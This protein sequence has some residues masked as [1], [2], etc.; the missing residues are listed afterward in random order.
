MSKL[1]IDNRT[2]RETEYLLA[3][4]GAVLMLG[5]DGRVDGAK[6]EFDDGVRF[7]VIRN[8]RSMRYLV[9]QG[10]SMEVDGVPG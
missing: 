2:G 6:I 10:N 1:I 9:L 8:E 7:E 4:L 3:H 5:A